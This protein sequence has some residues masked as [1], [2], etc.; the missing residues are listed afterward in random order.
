MRQ[1]PS[2][3]MAVVA[4]AGAAFLVTICCLLWPSRRDALVVYCAH[5]SVYSQSVLDDFTKRT[6]IPVA[7]KFDTEA[8]KSLGLVELLLREKN[9]PHCDVFWNNELLGTLDLAEQ[10]LLEPYRGT[11][12]E[13]IPAAFKDTD[14]RW[15]GF[16]GRLRVYIVNTTK[17]TPTPNAVATTLNGDLSRVAIAK[18]L[19]GTTLTQYCVLWQL[20]GEEK[21]KAW[22]RDLRQRRICEVLGNSTVKNLVAEGTCDLG[23]TDSD[24]A[25]V[26]KD[27]GK[28]VALLPVR[29]DT[30]ATICIPN[31]VG[32]IKG[33][34]RL[35]AAQKLV[36]F[37]LSEECE[38]ALARCQA[39]QVPLGPVAPDKLP[40][41]V[42]E[43]SQWVASGYPLTDLAPARRACL[44][45]L[46][47]EYVGGR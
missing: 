41:E 31:T 43:L 37:L 21:L 11:G 38:L 14:G 19:F 47:S 30:G 26:A 23:F 42:Q 24:D 34:R 12:F 2:K 16:A 45:W 9:H 33:T 6:G 32:I 1:R 7:V 36:D 15:V 46:K 20:W 5:D 8:T 40:A 25:F 29:T 13:R 10:G 22:H 27:E 18:P 28:P 39:R 3:G 44:A 35:D 17:A 4:G